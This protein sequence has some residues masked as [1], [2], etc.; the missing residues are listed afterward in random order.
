MLQRAEA[1]LDRAYRALGD[2]AD[3]LRS[4]RHPV[5]SPLTDAQA[6]RR[7]LGPAPRKIE[8]LAG[9]SEVVLVRRRDLGARCLRA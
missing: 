3:W 7:R 5:S 9:A 8:R 1:E 2:A 6:A 4:D